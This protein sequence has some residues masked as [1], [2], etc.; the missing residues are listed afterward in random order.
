MR[1]HHWLKSAFVLAPLVFS[2]QFLELTAITDAAIAFALFSVAAS[3]TYVWNDLQDIH[4]DRL[5][6]VKRYTRPLAAGA[7]SPTSAW[8]LL[9]VLLAILVA[10]AWLQ[11]FVV[12]I[13]G[14]YLA[15]N[16]ASSLPITEVAVVDIFA[17]SSGFVLR[18]FAGAIAIGVAVSAWML[19]TTLC[20]AL[21][22][23]ANKR[24]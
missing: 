12:G 5:H 21:Y 14:V 3:A 13:I 9:G 18:V 10:G 6:P 23:T 7:V 8:V 15:I 22:L 11:P 4:Q 2:G 16:A 1:P 24:R 17:V 19:V 20:V